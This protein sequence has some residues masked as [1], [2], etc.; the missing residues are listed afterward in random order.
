METLQKTTTTE[1]IV[2]MRYCAENWNGMETEDGE[3]NFEAQPLTEVE[4]TVE[5]PSDA[6]PW[7]VYWE[8]DKLV[9]LIEVEKE[10]NEEGGYGA[11]G[12]G[13]LIENQSTGIT[14]VISYDSVRS[15]TSWDEFYTLRS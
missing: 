6:T 15:N 13:M 3:I 12:D 9:D 5:L 8:A 1:Y 14:Y 4:V 7:E 10:L 11:E 2:N